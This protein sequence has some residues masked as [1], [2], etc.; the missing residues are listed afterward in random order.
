MPDFPR[1]FLQ[2]AFVEYLNGPQLVKSM[3]K[4]DPEAE[5]IP[6]VPGVAPL[7]QTYPLLPLLLN[8]CN[9]VDDNQRKSLFEFLNLALT[10]EKE[11]TEQ[12]V[13]L[14][15]IGIAEHNLRQAEVNAFYSGQTQALK[16]SQQRAMQMVAEFELQHKEVACETETKLNLL[17]RFNGN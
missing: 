5:L 10:F 9:Y 14:F 17:S 13:Q 8:P 15:E 1:C 3:L 2:D 11:I 16:D 12:C 4:D 6:C 7:L